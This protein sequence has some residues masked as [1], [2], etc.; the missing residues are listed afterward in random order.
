MENTQPTLV[1]KPEKGFET[2]NT[3]PTVTAKPE[4]GFE[5]MKLSPST[6]R[7]LGEMGF[8]KPTE[9]QVAALPLVLAGR[10]LTGQARTGTG[11]TAVFGICIAERV[12]P[13]AHGVQALILAPTRELSLQIVEELRKIGK[14]SQLRLLA[15]YGGQSITVQINGLRRGV[16]VVVGTPGRILDHL[17]RGTLRLDKVRFVVLDEADRMLDMGFIDDVKEIVQKT[18]KD[19][20]TMLFSATMPA[21]VVRLSR[22]YQ[23]NPENISVSKDEITVT[24]IPHTYAQVANEDRL[25]ALLEYLKLKR[26]FHTLVFCKMKHTADKVVHELRKNGFLAEALHG[27]LSQSKRD[28]VTHK[29]RTGELRLLVATDLAARG[30]DIPEISHVINFNLPME[31]MVYTH[32]VGRTGRAGQGGTAFSIITPDEFGYLR[33]IERECRIRM[34]EEK[35][36]LP[37]APEGLVKS[38]FD[39][40]W[41]GGRGGGAGGRRGGGPARGGFRKGGRF[42]GRGGG[43]PRR[44]ARPPRRSPRY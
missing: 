19:R 36:E 5:A 14:Y 27:N 26:P 9:I 1:T 32:R 24:H 44:G 18:L 16:H 34:T 13:K 40:H 10:D 22:N 29:F 3:R 25:R 43:A 31:I 15:I 38:E 4:N 8:E 17:E 11:K 42:G 33:Q 35:L 7:A 6:L 12:D 2:K 30:L 39:S 21:E 37:P 23:R 28:Y 41:G 20:Q